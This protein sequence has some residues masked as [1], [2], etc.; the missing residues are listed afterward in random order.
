VIWHQLATRTAQDRALKVVG[1]I[2]PWTNANQS[3][4]LEIQP[5]LCFAEVLDHICRY[6][7]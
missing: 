6:G 3:A 1:G 4:A 5:V 2:K 7:G